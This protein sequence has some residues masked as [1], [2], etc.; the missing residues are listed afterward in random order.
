MTDEVH[1][2]LKPC[3]EG[4]QPMDKV[5]TWGDESP[6]K[7]FRVTWSKMCEAAKVNVLLHDFR[8]TAA[9][10]MVR[11]GISKLTAKRIS[12]HAADSVFDRYDIGDKADLQHAAEKLQARKLRAN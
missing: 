10:K 12:G 6:M 5:F 8:R 4:K 2:L 3:V 11:A 1:L 7:D 9:R